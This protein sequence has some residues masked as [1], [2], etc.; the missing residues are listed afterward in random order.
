M[1]G[2]GVNGEIVS[3]GRK[4]RV[5]YAWYILATA[6]AI[7]TVNSGLTVYGFST[8]Y[9]PWE[10]EFGWTR[11][12]ISLAM[13][14]SGIVTGLVSPWFGRWTDKYGA[15]KV[16]AA[17]AVLFGGPFLAMTAT[18]TIAPFDAALALPF[19]H[20]MFIVMALGR[21]AT[22]N[23]PLSTAIAH[24]F[25]KGRGLAMG[26]QSTGVGLGGVVV[27]PVLAFMIATLG[28]RTTFIIGGFAVFIII[29]PLCVF[30]LRH[31]PGEKGLTPYGQDD[32]PMASGSNAK[33][34]V[35][36]RQPPGVDYH[37]TLKEAMRTLPFWCLG[38]S[39]GLFFFGNGTILQHAFPLFIEKG[40]SL[41]VAAGFLS[42]IASLGVIGKLTAG[43]AAD[44]MSTSRYVM[45]GS[46]I[47][48]AVGIAILLVANTIPLYWIGIIILG[49][50]MGGAVALQPVLLGEC[51]G[52]ASFG[53][54]LGALSVMLTVGASLGPLYAGYTHDWTG[55]Y[56]LALI[57]ATVLV[58]VAAVAIFFAKPV[59]PPVAQ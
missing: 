35:T 26:I 23:I 25:V 16:V 9:Q 59:R 2:R 49:L 27:A 10:A 44:R 32:S 22:S 36:R 45:T 58:L 39:Q 20:S 52:T 6:V 37:W 17:G 41:A 13:F 48:Q 31:R 21:S 14:V 7:A 3:T 8:F 24:W 40:E 5:H 34:K 51:Y 18:G 28:W 1:A 56:Q 42:A 57:T 29:L 15:Q 43:Y 12:E 4:T 30:V 54:L 55:N 19:L 33:E 53:A 50:S 47:F 11:G 38:I 46:V